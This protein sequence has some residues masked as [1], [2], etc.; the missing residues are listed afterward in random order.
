MGKDIF[1]DKWPEVPLHSGELVITAQLRGQQGINAG[2][3]GLHPFE[4]FDMPQQ[5]GDA[6]RFAK[7]YGGLGCQGQSTGG[8][9]GAQDDQLLQGLAVQQGVILLV[10]AAEQQ[11]YVL[12]VMAKL[13]P[14][15]GTNSASS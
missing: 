7:Q 12:E 6:I 8:I 9:I 15:V 13:S 3:G 4:T 5:R 1:A 11:Q 2:I 10:V 14:I